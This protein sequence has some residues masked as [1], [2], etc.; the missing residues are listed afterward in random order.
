MM[1]DWVDEYRLTDEARDLRNVEIA[2]ERIRSTIGGVPCSIG[3][4]VR[5]YFRQ[6]SQASAQMENTDL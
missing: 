3:G 2:R 6:S 5:S 4:G 1:S